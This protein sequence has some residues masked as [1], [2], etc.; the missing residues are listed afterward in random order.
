[1]NYRSL[2]YIIHELH[3]RYLGCLPLTTAESLAN[4]LL[5]CRFEN[6]HTQEFISSQFNRDQIL[7]LIKT[8]MDA[9]GIETVKRLEV[10]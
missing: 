4:V 3:Q 8:K 10:C 2:I 6:Q 7:N 5:Y 1:M 9:D